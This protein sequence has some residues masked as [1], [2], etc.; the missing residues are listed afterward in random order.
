L[1]KANVN[2]GGCRDEAEEDGEELH[3]SW[4]Q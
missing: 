3:F 2:S 4:V 1:L